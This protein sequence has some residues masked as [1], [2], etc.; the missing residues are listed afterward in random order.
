LK[1]IVLRLIFFIENVFILVNYSQVHI[2]KVALQIY[3][4][5]IQIILSLIVSTKSNHIGNSI[6]LA[7]ALSDKVSK[8]KENLQKIPQILS[9]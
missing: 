7:I 5:M 8:K 4:S 9:E 3:F 1:I 2:Q 6:Q